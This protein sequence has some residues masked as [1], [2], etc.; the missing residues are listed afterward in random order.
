MAILAI[1]ETFGSS[2]KI[3][4]NKSYLE[5]NYPELKLPAIAIMLR[6]D[7]SF[8]VDLNNNSNQHLEAYA[9]PFRIPRLEGKVTS[10]T[11]EGTSSKKVNI[12]LW[13]NPK[14][15]QKDVK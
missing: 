9:T 6:G 11:L 3:A 7:A 10:Y 12:I 15:K 2:G 8:S 14:R 1:E 5:K 13:Y 4:R